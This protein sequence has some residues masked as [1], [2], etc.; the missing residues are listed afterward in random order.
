MSIS[1]MPPQLILPLDTA[2]DE[3]KEDKAE[4]AETITP[5]APSVVPQ[6]T[7]VFSTAASPRKQLE[8]HTRA[9]LDVRRAS[10]LLEQ[11]AK[12]IKMRGLAMVGIFRPFR[13][14]E[15][16][17]EVERLIELFLLSSEPHVYQGIFALE[18]SASSALF[19]ETLG[20]P[21]PEVEFRRKL[22]YANVHDV[23][24]L[25]KWGVRRMTLR[26]SDL[27][28]S[29]Q[30]SWY[31]N[32]VRKEK[33]SKYPAKAFS[34]LLLPTMGND[35]ARLLQ[36][37]FDLMSTV[38]AHHISNAMPAWRL[39][40]TLG[41]W[42]FGRVGVDHEPVNFTTMYHAWE[43]AGKVTEHLLLTFIREQSSQF[44][45]MPSRLTELVAD[46]PHI[47]ADE[48]APSLPPAFVPPTSAA[49]FVE[50]RTDNVVLTP[51]QPRRS[52]RDT[53]S[54]ALRAR[55]P[56]LEASEDLDDWMAIIASVER[57]VKASLEPIE[58]M[59]EDDVEFKVNGDPA[60]GNNSEVI[61]QE[62]A[63][64]NDE[65]A[66]TL[67]ITASE[68][69]KRKDIF[70]DR[71]NSR[72]LRASS[73]VSGGI[74]SY[75]SVSSLFSRRTVD[76]SSTAP[77]LSSSLSRSSSLA[78]SGGSALAPLSE[79]GDVNF[80]WNAFSSSGFGSSTPQVDQL[81]LNKAF[82]PKT[83][84]EKVFE[85][86]DRLEAIALDKKGGRRR[87]GLPHV[88]EKRGPPV[89]VLTGV[90]T[91][92]FNDCFASVWQ[93]QLLDDCPAVRMPHLICAQLNPITASSLLG[94][95]ASAGAKTTGHWL[96]VNETVVP[97]RPPMPPSP[98]STFLGRRAST[99]RKGGSLRSQR[100]SVSDEFGSTGWDASTASQDDDD[101]QS[102]F[103]IRSGISA[104]F[105]RPANGLRRMR[106]M[107][108]AR[109][110]PQNGLSSRSEIWSE[111]SGQPT[112]STKKQADIDA[113]VRELQAAVHADRKRIRQEAE[114]KA[115][116]D[117]PPAVNDEKSAVAAIVGAGAN[118]S[119]N[120]AQ[121]DGED[122]IEKDQT[123]VSAAEVAEQKHN[124]PDSLGVSSRHETVTYSAQ[125]SPTSRYQDAHDE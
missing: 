26:L 32:F 19:R 86:Q 115:Q 125:S 40:R 15:S 48:S 74:T 123:K 31:E 9:R 119:T 118:A 124:K 51:K 106:S 81:E 77:E 111:N 66:R 43:R 112:S 68:L 8:Y 33:E 21:D 59:A 22:A 75:D 94:N 27:R 38:A 88:Q 12:E 101:R 14:S 76:S 6:H 107:L 89:Y 4:E 11:C 109:K 113:E 73:D 84:L 83:E 100:Q 49:L 36:I 24:A 58:M 108:S 54:A 18:T 57:S 71:F 28:S 67:D 56:D 98:S 23:V 39:S 78:K 30:Y 105:M 91:V 55:N 95:A 103:S 63:L 97:P 29:D 64:F 80:D 3:M 79:N 52:P 60:H 25:F 96:I 13:T 99:F 72:S 93:D 50:L 65:D 122:A 7:S 120:G 20:K 104:H 61:Y 117:Q 116:E 35:T 34:T 121:L 1:P 92:T 46:Y 41:F 17:S 90:S 82:K 47:A 69:R 85:E 5:T 114:R 62:L 53:L 2:D 37:V 42:L 10:S 87:N 45:L 102:L 16:L 44:H 110:A 70:E